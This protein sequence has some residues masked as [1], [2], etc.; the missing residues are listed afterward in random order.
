MGKEVILRRSR[1]KE[2]E[3]ELEILKTVKR[4]EIAE[5]IKLARDFGDLS[6]NSEYDEAKNDQAFL[7]GEI[8]R[9]EAMLRNAV[10]VDDDADKSEE[11]V[12]VGSKVK[13]YDTEFDEEL[14]YEIVGATEADISQNKVTTDSPVGQALLNRKVGET[15]KVNTPGGELE[16]KILGLMG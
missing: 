12:S 13:L 16:F 7:E 1:F 8:I 15:V 10:I 4:R 2:W 14:V 5:R 11:T 3:K 9:I 6:E